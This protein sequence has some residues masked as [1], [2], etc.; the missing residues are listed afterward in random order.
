M[1]AFLQELSKLGWIEGKNIT[2]EYRFAEQKNERLPEL[3]A[4]LVRLKVDLIVTPSTTSALAAKKATTT[5]PIVMT[6]V[7]D[8]VGAGLIAN[9]ARPG[10]N[11]TGNATL[12]S[13]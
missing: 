2:I 13:S 12:T 9:L 11:V 5:I 7:G 10:G 3:A 4:E 8:P 1:K 6:N